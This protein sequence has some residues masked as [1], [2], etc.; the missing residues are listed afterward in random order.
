M[1]VLKLCNGYMDENEMFSLMSSIAEEVAPLQVLLT[2]LYAY[3][4]YE[5]VTGRSAPRD[6]NF[7]VDEVGNIWLSS[8]RRGS[9][10][11]V[12]PASDFA[13]WLE[14][15]SGR[16]TVVGVIVENRLVSNITIASIPDDDYHKSVVARHAEAW[17]GEM[18]RLCLAPIRIRPDKGEI[19]EVPL[20]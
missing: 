6:V 5:F 11:D 4:A 3:D 8:K 10:Y 16:G 12:V 9:D 13:K 19:R 14:E 17:D 7:R 20:G 15:K 2:D 1:N 18:G